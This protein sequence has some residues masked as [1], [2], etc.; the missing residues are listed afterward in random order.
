MAE[1]ININKD[2][3]LMREGEE[4]CEMYYLKTG[5]LGVYKLKGSIEQQIGT[6]YAG[7][8]VGEMSFLDNEPRCATI[9]ALDDCELSVIPR[10][11][12]DQYL[13]KQPSWLKAL[14]GT[15]VD[16]LRKANQ[17]IRV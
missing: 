14:H 9:R 12:M 7:E 17:R 15:L 11:K 4:S 3:F 16:R 10:D 5:L 13:A 6:I 1:L 2:D 8:L